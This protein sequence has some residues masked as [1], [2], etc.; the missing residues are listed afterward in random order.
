MNFVNIVDGSR[1]QFKAGFGVFGP[2]FFIVF[3]LADHRGFELGS[4]AYR[5]V[6]GV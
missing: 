2:G 4:E 1:L 6:V 3:S 5:C